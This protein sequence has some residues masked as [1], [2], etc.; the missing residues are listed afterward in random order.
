MS[1]AIQIPDIDQKLA[2]YLGIRNERIAPV[3]APELVPVIVM[4]DLSQQPTQGVSAGKRVL[5]AHTTPVVHPATGAYFEF[6]NP[7]GSGHVLRFLRWFV[8]SST[9]H[10]W[11][12]LRMVPSG[13]AFDPIYRGESSWEDFTLSFPSTGDMSGIVHISAAA[14]AALGPGIVCIVS[15]SD[16]NTPVEIVGTNFLAG[17]GDSMIVQ[18]TT[19]GGVG[20]VACRIEVSPLRT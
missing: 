12:F 9:R 4:A 14:G 5:Y 8:R 20:E 2:R 3:V 1:N 15:Q 6:H 10:D 19:V 18:T 11:N 13:P 7:E 17:P 16:Q